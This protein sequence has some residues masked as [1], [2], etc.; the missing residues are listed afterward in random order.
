MWYK[1]IRWSALFLSS[2]V[3]CRLSTNTFGIGERD[4]SEGLRWRQSPSWCSR[5]VVSHV[6]RRFRNWQFIN[7]YV[8]LFVSS[9]WQTNGTEERENLA[10]QTSTSTPAACLQESTTWWNARQKSN[11]ITALWRW[12]NSWRH[13]WEMKLLSC[14]YMGFGA[15]VKNVNCFSS[16]HK[17]ILMM[18]A[19]FRRFE[20]C[21][22]KCCVVS[23]IHRPLYPLNKGWGSRRTVLDISVKRK[24]CLS[25]GIE[26][27]A[28]C[29]SVQVS[30]YSHFFRQNSIWISPV[31]VI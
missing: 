1:A 9:R 29:N 26:L 31:Q 10:A 15:W 13:P 5:S 28:L 14:V 12:D 3:P 24:M 30:V 21:R 23:F 27:E 22:C 2:E 11:R 25:R 8:D 6:N 20:F 4:R 18:N 19:Q 17:N 7:L 16:N